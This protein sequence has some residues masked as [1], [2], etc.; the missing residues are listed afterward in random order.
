MLPPLKHIIRLSL[1]VLLMGNLVSCQS[2][3]EAKTII[4]E[5]DSLLAK[6]V[7]MR[8]TAALTRAIE[9]LDKPITRKLARE[10]L[11]EAYYLM[12]QNLDDYHHNFA[13]AADYYIEADRLKTK[14]LFLRGR[15]NSSAPE[16]SLVWDTGVN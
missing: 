15:I 2:W 16:K 6:G 4:V 12:G 10:E 11:A 13:D 9:A 5:A 3:H 1:F 14:D 7:I 8:D